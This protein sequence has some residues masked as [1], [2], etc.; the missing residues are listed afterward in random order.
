MVALADRGIPAGA[1][2]LAGFCEGLGSRPVYLQSL[3]SDAV[4][5]HRVLGNGFST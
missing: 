2:R 1:G 4:P 3:L 5:G